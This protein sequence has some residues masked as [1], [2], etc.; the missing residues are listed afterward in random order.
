MRDARV[1][2]CLPFGTDPHVREEYVS[3]AG[4]IRIAKLLEECVARVLG[5]VMN[6]AWAHNGVV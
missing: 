1:V 5:S 6:G 3:F 4:S 2:E